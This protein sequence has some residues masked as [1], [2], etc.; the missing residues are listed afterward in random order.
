MHYGHPVSSSA[1][2]ANEPP[3]MV[4]D[5]MK[6]LPKPSLRTAVGLGAIAA[7]VV[8]AKARRGNGHAMAAG[9]RMR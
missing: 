6:W 3:E 4:L 2:Q 7:V 8:A 1:P 5:A 9:N